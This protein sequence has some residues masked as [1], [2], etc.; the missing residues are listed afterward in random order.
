M[1]L[2]IEFRHGVWHGRPMRR[3]R[4]FALV[5]AATTSLVACGDDGGS[6][7]TPDAPTTPD[8]AITPDSGPSCTAVTLGG[9]P[10]FDDRSNENYI[11]WT[12]ELTASL[13]SGDTFLSLEFYGGAVSGTVNL[14]A[15]TEANYKSCT[16]CFVLY[17]INAAGDAVEKNF[18]Q[19]GGTLTLAQDPFTN[20]VLM[21]TTTDLTLTEV[22]IDPENEYTSTPVPGGTCV[23]FGSLTLMADS[24]PA[25][26]TCEK[27]KYDDGTTC[28]CA[29]GAPDPDCDLDEPPVAG[30]TTG[31]VCSSEGTCLDVCNVVP[32]DSCPANSVCGYETADRDI[33]YTDLTVLD[34]AA[35]G[36]ACASANPLFCAKNANNVAAGVC[37]QFERDDLSCRKACDTNTDCAN[38]ETC[39]A[40]IGTKGICVAT[41]A[42]DT[43]ANATALTIGA[44][45]I[46]GT[47]GGA[48][49]NFD[50]GLE[51]AAC[52]GFAQ[53]GGDVAYSVALTA[54]QAIT[55]TLSGV[56]ARFDP[57]IALIGP[58]ASACPATPATALTCLKGADAGTRGAGETFTFTA[59][60]AGTY[61]IIVDTYTGSQGGSFSI[62]VT[63][64]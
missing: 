43:C 60:D 25:E 38:G 50:K 36:A 22:T 31:Q 39:A 59:N 64:N 9:A 52:T 44:A 37:D 4:S 57:A 45:A 26:W 56:S 19:S 8:S 7:S 6:P 23:S 54:G 42:N 29:C 10:I 51:T 61:Y 34:P 20:Q 3:L 58:G 41:P 1:S 28:D 53:P 33:C 35:L 11:G 18:F 27:S 55:V 63:S 62:A 46:T 49:N 16:A 13:G 21:G 40:I 2:T 14:G 30:C 5:A 15:G 17:V 12:Q 47:T 24:V 32:A 48:A